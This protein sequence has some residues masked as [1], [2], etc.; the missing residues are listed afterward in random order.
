MLSDTVLQ[1]AKPVSLRF[2]GAYF[3]TMRPYLLFVSGIT[4]IVGM[5]L[6]PEVDTPRALILGLVFFSSYGFGQALTDC[7]Q[8]DTDSISAPY[9]PL[10]R[11]TL[12][13]RDVLAVSILGLL[14][15][16]AV[17]TV[18]NPINAVPAMLTVLGLA[19]YTPFKRRWWGGPFYNSWIVALVAVIGYLAASG[20]THAEAVLSLA[21]AGMLIVVFFGYANFV[22]AGYFKDISADRATGYRTFPVEFGRKRSSV[23]SDL[24]ALATV[25]GCCIAIFTVLA[26]PV[27][28]PAALVASLFISGGTTAVIVAQIRLHEVKTDTE[29]HH[30]IQPVVHGYILLLSGVATLNQPDWAAF[31]VAFYLTFMITMKLRPLEAQI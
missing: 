28:I 7:F 21:F 2:L 20:T 16:G 23:A 6:A 10:V 18:Y 17:V 12:Q 9:R 13:R 11:G 15:C 14:L 3:V 8:L 22:L 25:G 19:T 4:G 31:L 26:G 27:S 30:A 29:A 5:S 1:P 24:L